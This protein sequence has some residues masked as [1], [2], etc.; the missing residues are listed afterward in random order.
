MNLGK[1]RKLENGTF[2]ESIT[3]PFSNFNSNKKQYYYTPQK[4]N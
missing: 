3:V 2:L 4:Q 1:V